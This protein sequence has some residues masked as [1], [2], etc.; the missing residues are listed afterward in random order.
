MNRC[1][2]AEEKKECVMRR[3]QIQRRKKRKQRRKL[4]LKEITHP[5]GLLVLL[6]PHFTSEESYEVLYGATRKART[7]V[8]A[9]NDIASLLTSEWLNAS[10]E[11][12]APASPALPSP[13]RRRWWKAAG[14]PPDGITKNLQRVEESIQNPHC[15]QHALYRLRVSQGR[16]KEKSGVW[17]VFRHTE[18][19]KLSGDCGVPIKMR[20]EEYLVRRT[21]TGIDA[22]STTFV[23]L[24]HYEIA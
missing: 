4:L 19:Q 5:F 20:R 2:N 3:R 11:I 22:F 23:P 15:I 7:I 1:Q 9:A 17:C 13:R 24:F 8:R 14:S 21:Q 6:T 12:E 18:W 10:S 16:L